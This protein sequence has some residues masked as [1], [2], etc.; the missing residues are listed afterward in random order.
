MGTWR[1]GLGVVGMEGMVGGRGAG[2]SDIRWLRVGRGILWEGFC[3]W[4]VE[5]LEN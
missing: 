2:G 1:D 3:G 4:V 5:I